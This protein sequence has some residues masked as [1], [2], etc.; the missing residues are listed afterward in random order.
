MGK[1]CA[2]INV[3]KRFL[4]CCGLEGEI[5]ACAKAGVADYSHRQASID[6]L[7]GAIE[8]TVRGELLC[9]PRIAGMLLRS[10]NLLASGIRASEQSC[11]NSAG[12]RNHLA[13]R[14][15]PLQQG[16]CSASSH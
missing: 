3:G 16:G 10:L 8:S 1:I 15:M 6:E 13:D 7:V 2:G 9:P 11:A 4:L 14:W 12:T 5:L